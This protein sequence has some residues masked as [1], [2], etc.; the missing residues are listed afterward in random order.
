MLG[1]P[2]PNIILHDSTEIHY[3]LTHTHTHT[4]THIHTHTDTDPDT[5]NNNYVANQHNTAKL[6]ET[7]LPFINE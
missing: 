5:H 6:Q 3:S 7:S 1:F 4:H 2:T